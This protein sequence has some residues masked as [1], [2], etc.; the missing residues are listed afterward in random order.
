MSKEEEQA[1]KASESDDIGPAGPHRGPR[2]DF[3]RPDEKVKQTTVSASSVEDLIAQI[4]GVNWDD[5][6]AVDRKPPVGG[7]FDFFA[8]ASHTAFVGKYPLG[9]VT[10][11]HRQMR[12]MLKDVMTRHGFKGIKN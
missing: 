12:L 7:H 11:A 6:E 2:P 8:Q 1:K 10:N 9:Q 4:Q 5:I 3:M